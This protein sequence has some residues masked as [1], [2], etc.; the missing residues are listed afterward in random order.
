MRDMPDG[1]PIS[2]TWVSSYLS[3]A[4]SWVSSPLSVLG[5]ST[6]SHASYMS[7]I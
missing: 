1:C 4:A 7:F 6:Y 2:P 5:K 3:Y